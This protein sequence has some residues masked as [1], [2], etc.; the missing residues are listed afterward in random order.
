MDKT[1]QLT[2]IL[3]NETQWGKPTVPFWA[4]P[5]TP[6]VYDVLV[7]Q[8]AITLRTELQPNIANQISW[9]ECGH[10]KEYLILAVAAL[11]AIGIDRPCEVT[12]DKP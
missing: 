2:A 10:K 1:D 6:N 7:E 8:I 5:C 9:Q 3:V 11:S 12:E 4:F